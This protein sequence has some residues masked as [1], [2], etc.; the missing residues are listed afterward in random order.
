MQEYPPI[1]D[2]VSLFVNYLQI[3]YELKEACTKALDVYGNLLNNWE[4]ESIELLQTSTM[5]LL[6]NATIDGGSFTDFDVDSFCEYYREKVKAMQHGANFN[7]FTSM[8][9]SDAEKYTK[10]IESTYE[11]FK[12]YYE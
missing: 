6:T 8:V 10:R 12:R 2:P 7:A 11:D 9:K 5:G 1:D 3:A 4:R